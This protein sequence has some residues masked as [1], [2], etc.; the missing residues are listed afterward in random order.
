MLELTGYED[1]N[2]KVIDIEW[3]EGREDRETEAVVKITNP[4]EGRLDSHMG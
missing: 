2:Y 3:G 1:V 4:I